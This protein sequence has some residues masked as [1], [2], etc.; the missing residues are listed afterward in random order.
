[1]RWE[2]YGV[3]YHTGLTVSPVGGGDAA[4]EFPDVTSVNSGPPVVVPVRPTSIHPG[5]ERAV[6]WSKLAEQ[7]HHAYKNDMNNLAPVSVFHGRYWF[8]E[9]KTT[10]HGG[11]Q[12]TYQGGGRFLTMNPYRFTSG[13]TNSPTYADPTICIWI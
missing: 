3:P 6:C 11:Y 9:G 12:I 1:V 7:Q 13:A 5:P 8:G 4:L 10:M 2:Y